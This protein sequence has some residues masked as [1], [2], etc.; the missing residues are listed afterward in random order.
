LNFEKGSTDSLDE[1]EEER[2]VK[3]QHDTKS[4]SLKIKSQPTNAM[5]EL[6]W[7]THVFSPSLPLFFFL[8]SHGNVWY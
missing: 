6:M 1:N 2:E 8:F 4:L 3:Q 7:H 5:V